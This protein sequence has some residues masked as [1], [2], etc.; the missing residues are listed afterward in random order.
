GSRGLPPSPLASCLRRG[1]IA[2]ARPTGRG[3]CRARGHAGQ[4]RCA[5]PAPHRP[6][7]T[8]FR[9]AAMTASL[10]YYKLAYDRGERAAGGPGMQAAYDP[11]E[12]EA[13]TAN[14]ARAL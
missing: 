1:P 7:Q 9:A 14:F 11:G 4:R 10:A 13:G 5:T 2:Q 12:I 8:G 6:V 3:S